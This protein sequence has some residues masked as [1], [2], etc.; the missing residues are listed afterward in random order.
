MDDPDVAGR[1]TML[2]WL[3]ERINADRPVAPNVLWH[4]TDAAGLQ[5]ILTSERLW[6]TQTRFLND[7]KE[8]AYGAEL[9]TRALAGYDVAGRKPATA[10]FV[11]G[12]GDPARRIIQ[13]F[14]DKTLD[15]FITCFCSDGDLLSQ[16]RA[17]A[18]RDS[19]GGYALGFRPPGEPAAWAQ[20][21][22][23]DHDLALRRVLYDHAEQMSTC[24]DLINRL[25]ELLDVD[26]Y[27][28]SRQ[29]AFANHLVDGIVE[30]ATWCKHPA[31]AEEREWRIVYLRSTDARPIPVRHRASRG[32]L[33]PYVELAL[34]KKVGEHYDHLPVTEIN[35]GPSP[36]PVLKQQGVRS[37]LAPMPPFADVTVLG[38]LAPLR[39]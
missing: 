11:R 10:R 9:A 19:A 34:P 21:A 14:L 16:W 26:P 38:S 32:L 15:V 22:P 3:T 37:L 18:G 30:L 25:V 28:I 33:V 6:A 27:D 39:L 35:C 20:S 1:R 17:Y 29:T 36:D 23:D 24:H 4:Y 5:G 7:S 2:D 31:F 12:L 8:I 13:N